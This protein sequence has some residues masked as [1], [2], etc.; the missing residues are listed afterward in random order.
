M[1]IRLRVSRDK[2][3][4]TVMNTVQVVSIMTC[5]IKW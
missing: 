3:L 2:D 1:N 5:I 4:S